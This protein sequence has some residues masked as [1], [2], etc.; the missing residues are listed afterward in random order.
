MQAVRQPMAV[1][2]VLSA[3]LLVA[4]LSQVRTDVRGG[5]VPEP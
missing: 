1:L 3:V 2:L 4:G 5:G